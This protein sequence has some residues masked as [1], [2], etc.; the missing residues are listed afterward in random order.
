M[1]LYTAER[2]APKR[3]NEI[4]RPRA[5]ER[6]PLAAAP[7]LPAFLGIWLAHRRSGAE[8]LAEVT[9]VAIDGSSAPEVAG[10]LLATTGDTVRVEV[11]MG[12][13]PESRDVL[14]YVGRLGWFEVTQRVRRQCKLILSLAAWPRR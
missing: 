4:R 12:R 8:Q 9:A 6:R 14:L 10:R 13:L 5:R 7:P 1:R 3:W 2:G 11:T